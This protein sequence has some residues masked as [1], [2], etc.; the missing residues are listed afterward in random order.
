MTLPSPK[1]VALTAAFTVLACCLAGPGADA[2]TSPIQAPPQGVCP[3]IAQPLCAAAGSV[4][5]NGTTLGLASQGLQEAGASGLGAFAEDAFG[6]MA[7]KFGEAGIS[8]L[9]SLS[10]VFVESS[11]VDLSAAGID[12]VLAITM[13]IAM[14]VA[15]LLVV[16]A[17]GKTALTGNGSTAAAAL[18]GL[19]KTMLVT[20]LL[21]AVTQMALKAA[22]G[23]SAWII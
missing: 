23:L 9:Q 7:Q 4:V 2:A 13:P 10:R 5:K 6:Q 12:P 1:A 22:D 3:G 17:A 11:T 20:I 18:V 14:L 21:V 8:F 19:V 16:T 15:L